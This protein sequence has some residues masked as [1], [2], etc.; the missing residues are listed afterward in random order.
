[1]GVLFL[2]LLPLAHA[3]LLVR[4]PSKENNLLFRGGY[5][6]EEKILDHDPYRRA[7]AAESSAGNDG[8]CGGGRWTIAENASARMP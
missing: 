1:M 4:M 7:A 2:L 6:N 3:I 5:E 8:V